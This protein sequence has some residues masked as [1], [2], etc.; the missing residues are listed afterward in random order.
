ML[1]SHTNNVSKS[2]NIM[3]PLF[4]Y[5]QTMNNVFLLVPPAVLVIIDD[6]SNFQDFIS[7]LKYIY[8]PFKWVSKVTKLDIGHKINV[9]IT[10][11]KF[12]CFLKLT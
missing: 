1:V 4:L 3:K 10:K 12:L 9:L 2:Q 8:T 11:K 7:F 6:P 5:F